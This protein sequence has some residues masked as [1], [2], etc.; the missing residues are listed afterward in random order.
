MLTKHIRRSD[1]Q[2]NP[3]EVEE[4]L[5]ESGFVIVNQ[6]RNLK[7]SDDKTDYGILVHPDLIDESLLKYLSSKYKS[8][9]KSRQG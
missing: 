8:L 3:D 9:L 5:N 6:K 7:A 1:I 4:K 2:N